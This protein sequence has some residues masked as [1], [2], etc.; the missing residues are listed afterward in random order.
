MTAVA[1]PVAATEMTRTQL[2]RAQRMHSKICYIEA[3]QKLISMLVPIPDSAIDALDLECFRRKLYT[4]ADDTHKLQIG[5][6]SK[7]E[8]EGDCGTHGVQCSWCGIWVP[9]PGATV[10]PAQDVTHAMESDPDTLLKQPEVEII[11][12]AD[13]L[14]PSLCKVVSACDGDQNRNL[15][16]ELRR[17]RVS[18]FKCR[19]QQGCA[20]SLPDWSWQHVDETMHVFCMQGPQP[21][22]ALSCRLQGLT[23]PWCIHKLARYCF[24]RTRT[25]EVPET[26]PER[27]S[28]PAALQFSADESTG[29]CKSQWIQVSG[30]I[31]GTIAHHLHKSK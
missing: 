23:K 18:A 21:E 8:P 5:I 31:F 3:K 10:Q 4:P 16:E 27:G 19:L 13:V 15:M 25:G 30:Y 9:L 17:Q 28:L 24:K 22:A 20:E 29:D 6:P 14:S 26:E 7:I 12:M 11:D 2:R 1:T